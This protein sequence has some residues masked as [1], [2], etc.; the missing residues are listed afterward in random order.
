MTKLTAGPAMAMA[1]SC[2]GLSGIFCRLAT[3]P[4]GSSVTSGA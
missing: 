2:D 1:N 3:P 4:I